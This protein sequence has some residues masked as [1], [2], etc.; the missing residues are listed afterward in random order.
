MMPIP[1]NN[2]NLISIDFKAFLYFVARSY[3]LASAVRCLQS[4]SRLAP[5]SWTAVA[6]AVPAFSLRQYL[7]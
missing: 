6:W 5:C 4:Q 7:T 3:V 2:Y 1:S